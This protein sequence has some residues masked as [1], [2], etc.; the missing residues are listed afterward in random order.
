[1]GG[2]GVAGRGRCCTDR[3]RPVAEICPAYAAMRDLPPSMP[4]GSR[5][6][7]SATPWSNDL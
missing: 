5:T 6:N 2:S 7:F 4:C 3:A 1:V